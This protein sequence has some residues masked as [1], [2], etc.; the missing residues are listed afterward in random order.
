MSHICLKSEAPPTPVGTGDRQR[1]P[2]PEI[3]GC[4][5][6][7]A[8]DVEVPPSVRAACDELGGQLAAAA[9]RGD[10]PAVLRF[11]RDRAFILLNYFSGIGARELCRLRCEDLHWAPTQLRLLAPRLTD[12]P[13]R[14]SRFCAHAA[15]RSWLQLADIEV[16]PVF[17]RVKTKG[18]IGTDALSPGDL[19]NLFWH[20][21]LVSRS[22]PD[23]PE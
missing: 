7:Q 4:P 2:E 15:L 20:A 22:D 23:A 8:A 3:I 19:A 16:G 21:L 10:F 1:S 13:A 11:S 9:Q 5:A 18:R 12:I 17:R 6:Q 14:E